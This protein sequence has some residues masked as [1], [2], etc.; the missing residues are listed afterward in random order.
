MDFMRYMSS[1]NNRKY[2]NIK[3]KKN[4]LFFLLLSSVVAMIAVNKADFIM[5][6]LLEIAACVFFVVINKDLIVPII[7]KLLNLKFVKKSL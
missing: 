3:I 5:L 7:C 2:F 6:V 4:I 1:P